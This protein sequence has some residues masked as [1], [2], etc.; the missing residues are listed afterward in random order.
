MELTPTPILKGYIETMPDYEYVIFDTPWD[1][2]DIQEADWTRF[3]QGDL[4][5]DSLTDLDSD[6]LEALGLDGFRGGLIG[7]N[8]NYNIETLKSITIDPP[9]SFTGRKRRKREITSDGGQEVNIDR[10]LQR[11]PEVWENLKQVKRPQRIIKML[12]NA[13]MNCGMQQKDMQEK[14]SVFIYMANLLIQSGYSVQIDSGW[15]SSN[16]STSQSLKHHLM[17]FVRIKQPFTPLDEN[18]TSFALCSIGFSRLSLGTALRFFYDI[19]DGCGRPCEIHTNLTKEY[20][21]V[22]NFKN[23][24]TTEQLKEWLNTYSAKAESGDFG[25]DKTEEAA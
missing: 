17:S 25:P 19:K 13:S 15:G 16:Y 22:M 14:A 2:L 8:S 7:E 1:V 6:F 12:F 11:D 9:E 18:S 10:F 23:R 4:G 21:I 20:D 3:G 24:P 5:K